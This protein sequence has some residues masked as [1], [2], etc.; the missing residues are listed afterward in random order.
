MKKQITEAEK[1]RKELVKELLQVS[2]VKSGEDINDIIKEMIGEMVGGTLDGELESHLGYSKYDTENKETMNS[3]NGYGDKKLQ[4]TYGNVD[5][6]VPRDRDGEYD[7]VIV[8]K[9]QKTVTKDLENKIISMYAKGMTTGDMETHIKEMYGLEISDST[10]SRITDRVLPIAK[11]WQVRP[12]EDI[13]AVVFLDAIHYHV[14]QDGRSIKKAVYIAI[15]I[16]LDGE[17][18]VL[19]LWIGENESSKFWLGVLNEIKNRGVD[20]ILIACVDGLSG[21]SE[22][23]SAAYPK[24]EIQKC[25]IHQIRNSTKFVTYKDIKKLMA[26]L[27]KVY[28]APTEEEA[29]IN[30][31]L[32]D[33]TWGKKYPKI[34]V[35]WRRNWTELSTYFKYPESVRKLIYTTNAIESFNRQLRKVT[36]NKGVFPTD[37]SLFKMLYLA[38]MDITKKWVSRRRDWGEIH[39]QLAIYFDDRIPD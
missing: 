15:G 25:V 7:P 6:K 28:K 30:L 9:Y 27:K 11:D 14:K 8:K 34:A 23:I 38:T 26:D 4:T 12:L 21:F 17:R 5:L 10:I 16:N 37:D 31:D 1:R 20:D 2:N 24:T 36:K 33:E 19:G 39:S 35:S 18:D 22:A 32:F 13:Y 29:L 3:R